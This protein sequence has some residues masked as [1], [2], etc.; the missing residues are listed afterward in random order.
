MRNKYWISLILLFTFVVW[1]LI[2]AAHIQAASDE[3]LL[4]SPSACPIEGCAAGQRLNFQATYA[5]SPVN[6]ANPNTQICVYTP[7]DGQSDATAE[8]WASPINSWM[9]ETGILTN[10]ILNEGETSA[11]CS[12]NTDSGDQWLLGAYTTYNTA[13]SDKIEFA[14][15]INPSSNRVGTVKVKIFALDSEDNWIASGTLSQ[16]IPV[17]PKASTVFVGGDATDCNGNIP[18]YINSGDDKLDGLGTG[19]RDAVMALDPSNTLY[20]LGQYEIKNNTVLI[21][22]N[23]NFM[24]Y[25]DSSITYGGTDCSLSM[26]KFTNGGKIKDLTINDGNCISPSRNLLAVDSLADVSIE[27]NTL[28]YG[29]R[30]IDIKNNLGI[31]TIAF[32]QISNNQD[33]AI[34]RAAGTGAI[35]NAFA[36]NIIDNR[37]GY[38]VI[39]NDYGIADHNYWGTGKSATSSAQYCA[40]SDAKRLGAPILQSSGGPGVEAVRKTVT[41][42]TSY[43][44][45]NNIGVRRSSGADFA[46]IIVNHGQGAQTN[47]PFDESGSPQ[48]EPCSNFYDIFLDGNAV[49]TNLIL[50]LK[51]DLNTDCINTIESSTYCGQS[52]STK[53]PLWWYD[54][55]KSITD[56]WDTTGQSPE[57]SG[58][59]G[60]SGQQTTCNMDNNLIRV[61]IDNT[62]RPNLLNDLN[63]TPFVAGILVSEGIQLS[64]FTGTFNVNKNEIVWTTTSETNVGGFHVLRSETANSGYTRVSPFIDADGDAFS[65]GTYS[66]VDDQ[67]SLNKLYYYKIEVLNQ[68][69][70]TIETHGPVSVSTTTVTPTSTRTPINSATPT[71][72]LYPTSTPRPTNTALPYQTPTS[73]YRPMTST[74]LSNPTQVRTYGPSATSGFILGTQSSP[75]STE[76]ILSLGFENG[77]PIQETLAF[78]ASAYPAANEEE[79]PIP[80][81]A[82]RAISELNI[83]TANEL[84][85]SGMDQE[86]ANGFI[87]I[88]WPYL[89]VGLLS[90]VVALGIISLSLSKS[91][92]S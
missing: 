1:L 36:N 30:A 7:A 42:T 73:S 80:T 84:A 19:L 78:S 62:G 79:M 26:L 28:T 4:H 92:F 6:N 48:I 10:V 45:N 32:N 67:I 82:E 58:A 76:S 71:R 77:Y 90:G 29:N 16:T 74:P 91:K 24:G 75:T 3:L 41:G 64:E 44:F 60:V 8:P 72:T 70:A 63:F 51:Y 21:D 53:Y 52:D 13:V 47:I 33:Y 50:S 81:I 37:S 25:Q 34:Y 39:C 61:V 69:G 11:L 38:Q 2:S 49:A 12:N 85:L 17:V 9:S 56:G 5:V 83:E 40:V 14:F 18:C 55:A 68:E 59:N 66:Y 43:A 20:I 23:L 27:H 54:P 15:N 35:L 57:G 87:D 22:K 86:N 46:I 89:G 31:I 65:G 88:Q